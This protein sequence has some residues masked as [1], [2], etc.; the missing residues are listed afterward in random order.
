MKYRNEDLVVTI[1]KIKKLQKSQRLSNL[2][3]TKSTNLNPS[4]E[5]K[6]NLVKVVKRDKLS[7]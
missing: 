6:D 7:D 4:Y 2:H 5:S 3:K 1:I